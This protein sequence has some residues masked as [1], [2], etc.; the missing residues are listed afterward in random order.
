MHSFAG[1]RFFEDCKDTTNYFAVAI[2]FVFE[3]GARK[4]FLINAL[5]GKAY[6]ESGSLKAAHDDKYKEKLKSIIKDEKIG[7][8]INRKLRN[9]EYPEEEKYR[10]GDSEVSFLYA[11]NKV[12]KF[13]ID[14]VQSLA[15]KITHK[16]ARIELHGFTTRDM[17]PCCLSYMEYFVEQSNKINLKSEKTN[18]AD[19]KDKG[20]GVNGSSNKD[21]L[22]NESISKQFDNGNKKEDKKEKSKDPFEN[23]PFKK[24]FQKKQKNNKE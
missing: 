20:K 19:P 2:N 22:D 18:N 15:K 7:N 24:V 21:V 6:F 8:Y 10:L 4:T 3:N 23:S 9:N 1:R 14:R 16:L 12:A 5:G 17:C 11:I 13:Q